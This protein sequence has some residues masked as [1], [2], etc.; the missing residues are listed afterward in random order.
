MENFVEFL[1]H[2]NIDFISNMSSETALTMYRDRYEKKKTKR[3]VVISFD[4]PMGFPP[5]ALNWDSSDILYFSNPTLDNEC[6]QQ[7]KIALADVELP[8]IVFIE[9]QNPLHL[10]KIKRWL[11]NFTSI[12][13]Q[14]EP[15]SNYPQFVLAEYQAPLL[16]MNF[17]ELKVGI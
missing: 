8:Y 16:R 11:K 3:C 5:F 9:R 2:R 12:V 15:T 14:N 7:I 6:Y 1:S 4:P 17:T 10:R 13:Y